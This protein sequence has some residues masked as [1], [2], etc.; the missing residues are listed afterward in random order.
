MNASDA[1]FA[2]K[3]ILDESLK[4]NSCLSSVFTKLGG[5]T[6]FQNYLKKFDGDFSVANL[7]LS[8]SGLLPNN[9]NAETSP[10]NNFLITI[11]FNSN[12]LNRPGIDVARTF[13]H[14]IIHAEMFRKLLSLSSS[15]GE[16][17][18]LKLNTMLTEHNYPG[19]YDYYRRYGVN[20]M[21]HELMAAHYRDLM[22][23]F[24][25]TYDNT[26]TEEQYQ[27]IAWSGL[28]ETSAWL[29]KTDL[30]KQKITD[31]YNSWY[32]STNKNCQ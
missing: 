13:M 18:V 3:V 30:E 20:N 9:I 23:A 25:K 7:K 11:T 27:A 2:N 19:L 16:I 26:L 22:I 29:Q 6:T 5:S 10:P 8:S 17:D 12:N 14:E 1:G 4:S 31:T 21:Q 32:L 28:K 15:N 24:L